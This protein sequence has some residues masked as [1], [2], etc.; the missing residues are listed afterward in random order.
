MMIALLCEPFV[1][2]RILFQTIH[3]RSVPQRAFLPLFSIGSRIGA[4]GGVV[5]IELRP[6]PPP[7][8]LL[9]EPLDDHAERHPRFFRE[10]L[11]LLTDH[12]WNTNQVRCS[13]PCP[14]LLRAVY[15]TEYT[16]SAPDAET[17]RELECGTLVDTIGHRTE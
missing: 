17:R 2:V 14:S 4:E 5:R 1:L 11:Q 12:F 10:C 13:Q 8:S 3:E 7:L 16:A 9:D 15:T 6:I